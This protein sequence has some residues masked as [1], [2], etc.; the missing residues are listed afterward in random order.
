M[1]FLRFDAGLNR[2]LAT[3]LLAVS[4]TL[5]ATAQQEPSE[6]HLSLA[7]EVIQGSG[8]SRSFDSVVPGVIEQLRQGY[9]RNRP[10]LIRDLEESIKAIQPEADKLRM[11]MLSAAA[12]VYAARLTEPEL[13]EIATFFRSAVGQKYVNSQPAILEG[14]YAEL[15]R[16]G[17]GVS[18]RLQASLRAE[19]KKRGHDI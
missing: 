5:P 10:E 1:S 17:A 13:G 19:M 16:W 18:D 9:S 12:R 4:L 2:L 15:Q 11:E 14:L 7:R 6:S 8:I 3:L